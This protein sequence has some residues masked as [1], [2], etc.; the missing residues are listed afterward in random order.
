MSPGVSRCLFLCCSAFLFSACERDPAQSLTGVNGHHVSVLDDPSPYGVNVNLLDPPNW[1]ASH[2][3]HPF[4]TYADHRKYLSWT[5]SAGIKWLRM[6]TH[7]ADVAS[8]N[9]DLIIGNAEL[10]RTDST[11]AMAQDSGFAVLMLIGTHTWANPDAG[12]YPGIPSLA[13]WSNFVSQIVSRHV[14][15]HT[16]M[17]F[18]LISRPVSSMRNRPRYLRPSYSSTYRDKGKSRGSAATI[19]A[20]T[21]RPRRVVFRVKQYAVISTGTGSPYRGGE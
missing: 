13:A 10:E 11:I 4:P 5:K 15:N 21:Y 7:W 16:S 17:M 14:G 20:R 12:T 3:G 9:G 6:G 1:A 2:P 8:S 18:P 19:P